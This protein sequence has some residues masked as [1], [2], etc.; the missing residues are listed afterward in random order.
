MTLPRRA[1]FVLCRTLRA[2]VGALAVVAVFHSNGAT[3][4]QAGPALQI[5]IAVV[6]RQKPEPPLD[7]PTATPQD[8]ALQGVRLAIADNNTTG[9]FLGQHFT[10]D[11][12]ILAP[13][14]VSRPRRRSA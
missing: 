2:A 13:Q 9:A 1:F 14:V 7:D 8:E 10:L 3:A 12:V 11:E 4:Q 5:E 6:V